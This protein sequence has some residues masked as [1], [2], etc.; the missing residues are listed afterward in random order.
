MVIRT[1]WFM[2][3]P[4]QAKYLLVVIVAMLAPTLVIGICLY[5]LLFYLLAK[6]MAFPEAIMANLVPVLD[7]VNALL[8]LSL[9]IITITIL[10]FAV[11]IS[12]RFAGPI[13]R[14]ENDLDRIL[15][16][17]IHHKI[18]V[19][20]KDDLKGIATRINALVARMKKQ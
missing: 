5:H 19:R 1:K 11:V 17:D 6:Q 4:I 15:E 3:H 14:L 2:R 8:A 20:K 9:P 18:H 13:E 16:G 10:I 12:H 7:K